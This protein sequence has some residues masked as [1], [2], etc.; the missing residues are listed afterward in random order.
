M[1]KRSDEEFVAL[2]RAEL[3]RSLGRLQPQTLARLSS[4]RD[5]A[6]GANTLPR[7]QDEEILVHLARSSIDE[8]AL[9]AGVEERLDQIRQQALARMPKQ[10]QNQGLFRHFRSWLQSVSFSWQVPASLA[11][12]GFVLVTA[13]SLF[14]PGNS[15]S[16]FSLE[17]E[18]ALVATAEDIELYEN[19]DFYLWLAENGFE[20][21]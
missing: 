5:R 6:L 15:N 3:E 14:L 9:P 20:I 12:T 8:E 10:E 19:L 1:I 21:Q 16:E 4:A 7:S 18:L 17:Q 2:V 13:V 11:A